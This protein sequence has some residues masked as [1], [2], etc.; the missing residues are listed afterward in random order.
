VPHRRF[1]LAVGCLALAFLVPAAPACKAAG[2]TVDGVV[3]TVNG[4]PILRSEM[5]ELLGKKNPTKEEWAAARR[6]LIVQKLLEKAAR[7]EKVEVTDEEVENLLMKRLKKLGL[8]PND[9]KERLPKY[10]RETR[11]YLMKRQLIIRRL[12]SKV[13]VLPA[14]IKAYYHE[15]EEEFRMEEKRRVRMISALIDKTAD[16]ETAR[17]AAGDKIQAV[18]RQLKEGKDFVLLARRESNDRYAEAGGDWGW[19]KEGDLVEALDKAAFSL[20]VGQISDIIETSQGFHIIRVEERRAE[21]IQPFNE[22]EKTI[23]DKLFTERFEEEKTKYLDSL[24]E[25]AHIVIYDEGPP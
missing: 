24:L 16:P 7:E 12:Q 22:V 17:K 20:E 15:H 1:L 14:E 6:E 23:R 21:S 19:K 25:N 2:V 10:R 3:C 8:E 9:V 18:M 11:R 13:I 5:A 4:I